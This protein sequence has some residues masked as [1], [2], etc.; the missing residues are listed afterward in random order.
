ML[1]IWTLNINPTAS[2]CN[3]SRIAHW[4]D[5]EAWKISST[6]RIQIPI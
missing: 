2:I 1:E 3:A 6:V 5:K 4:D